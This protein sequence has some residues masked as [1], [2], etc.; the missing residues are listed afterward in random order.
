VDG[1]GNDGGVGDVDEELV[2]LSAGSGDD[3]RA[4]RKGRG[5]GAMGVRE[6]VLLVGLVEADVVEVQ[7][8]RTAASADDSTAART[9]ASSVAESGSSGWGRGDAVTAVETATRRTARTSG[10]LIATRDRAGLLGMGFL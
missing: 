2:G 5:R 3:E 9:A 10:G 7:R 4:A 6:D 8:A 1:V